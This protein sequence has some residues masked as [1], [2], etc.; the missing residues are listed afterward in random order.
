MEGRNHRL[1]SKLISKVQ[2]IDG[3]WPMPVVSALGGRGRRSLSSR[4][5]GLYIVRPG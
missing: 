2:K 4:P 3:V 5:A 1:V